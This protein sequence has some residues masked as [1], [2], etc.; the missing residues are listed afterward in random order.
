MKMSSMLETAS[1]WQSFTPDINDGPQR[2]YEETYPSHIFLHSRSACKFSVQKHLALNKNV[3][4]YS[5]SVELAALES[6]K[7]YLSFWPNAP[8]FFICASTNL[9]VQPAAELLRLLRVLDSENVIIHLI[10]GSHMAS[11]LKS[12]EKWNAYH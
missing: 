1:S 3:V 10:S 6:R 12:A 8:S 5:L 11:I 2:L 9:S 7:T 4:T